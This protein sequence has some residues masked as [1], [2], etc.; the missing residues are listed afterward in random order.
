M[1]ETK[2]SSSSDNI[3][4]ISFSALLAVF[5]ADFFRLVRQFIVFLLRHKI[6]LVIFTITGLGIGIFLFNLTPPTYKLSM[7]VRPTEL[8]EKV[9]GEML[10]NLN[11]LAASGSRDELAKNLHINLGTSQKIIKISGI[12]IQD[13]ELIKD[14]TLKNDRPF[15]I[16]LLVRDNGIADSLQNAIVG[17]FESNPYLTKLKNDKIALY[18][19]RVDFINS[20]LKKLDSLKEIYNRF[21]GLSKTPTMYYNNS[22][23]PVKIYEISST[24]DAEKNAIEEWLMQNKNVLGV[25]DGVKPSRLPFSTGMHRVALLYGLIFFLIGCLLGLIIDGFRKK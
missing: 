23:D 9:F 12:N 20:E 21:L 14:T 3:A 24:Y 5:F 11:D 7:I 25:V 17:Y 19:K 22:M 4:P 15:V 16:E 6:L 8:S 10:K 1:Q 13:I 2:S 18:N